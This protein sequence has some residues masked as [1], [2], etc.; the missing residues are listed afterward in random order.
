MENILHPD[1]L[2]LN[3]S[4]SWSP[5]QRRKLVSRAIGLGIFEFVG[6][7]VV[8]AGIIA[9]DG[10]YVLAASFGLSV[11]LAGIE[12]TK[13][14]LDLRGGGVSSV[15]GLLQK[16]IDRDD[17]GVTY[18]FLL[19]GRTFSV[20]AEEFW[21]V[22]EGGPYRIWFSPRTKRILNT[23]PLPGWQKAPGLE[24]TT[25]SEVLSIGPAEEPRPPD[26]PFALRQSLSGGWLV[27]VGLRDW[28]FRRGELMCR[29]GIS[30]QYTRLADPRLRIDER[31]RGEQVDTSLQVVSARGAQTV[32]SATSRPAPGEATPL[33]QLGRF[34][35]AQTGFPLQ[36]NRMRE[37]SRQH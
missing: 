20:T 9:G 16:E 30:S 14:V 17:D 12:L 21:K 7:L 33:V 2:D 4:G 18:R 22:V 8:A 28:W 19:G 25:S 32:G 24:W 31:Y 11:I 34:M 36:V 37:R 35:A 5:R 3:R 10:G 15:D 27:G 13:A 29:W 26:A 23:A 6:I 1:E